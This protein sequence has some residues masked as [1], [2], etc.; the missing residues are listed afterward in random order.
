MQPLKR[1]RTQPALCLVRVEELRDC[2]MAAAGSALEAIKAKRDQRPASPQAS[3]EDSLDSE[4]GDTDE[5][6]RKK[7]EPR[8][9][10]K[11]AGEAPPLI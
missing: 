4:D 2:G 5:E 9:Q 8:T 3:E 1:V 11:D 7:E 6:E 10:V